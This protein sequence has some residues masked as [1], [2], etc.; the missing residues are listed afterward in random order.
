MKSNL[1]IERRF[2]LRGLPNGRSGGKDEEL[3]IHQYYLPQT[4]P[5]SI[6]RYRSVMTKGPLDGSLR[7]N[8]SYRYYHT[9]KNFLGGITCEE[10][11]KE[12]TLN[13]FVPVM[14]LYDRMIQKRRLIY[15]TYD[16]LKWEIDD[17]E[18]NGDFLVIAEIEIPSEDYELKIPEWLQDD[19]I[20]EITGMK[21]FSNSNLAR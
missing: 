9:I 3:F 21:E 11:E 15:Y 12:I 2:L 1:E 13:E 5:N 6:E 20:I 7:C 14:E 18:Y 19:I 17:F 8:D 10:I 16:N 4:D